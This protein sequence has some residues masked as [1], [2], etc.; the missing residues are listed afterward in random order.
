MPACAGRVFADRDHRQEA[1][2]AGKTGRILTD[3]FRRLS[4][5]YFIRVGLNRSHTAP[6]DQPCFKTP[7]T[8]DRERA[9]WFYRFVNEKIRIG[10]SRVGTR[11]SN[12]VSLH[13]L[14]VIQPTNKS[15]VCRPGS[16]S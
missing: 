11:S 16:P 13:P 4:P 8:L 12:C 10:F 9:F 1:N 14:S 6:T 3:Q 7:A 15:P 2:V 5:T